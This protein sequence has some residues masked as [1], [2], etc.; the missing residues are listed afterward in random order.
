MGKTA[1]LCGEVQA[2]REVWFERRRLPWWKAVLRFSRYETVECESFR[3]SYDEAVR[4]AEASWGVP[5]EVEERTV[6]DGP[7][8][9]H[10]HLI[11]RASDGE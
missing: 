6:E 2:I 7:H 5:V 8:R 11:V 9:G 4:K 10:V 1:I 3:D